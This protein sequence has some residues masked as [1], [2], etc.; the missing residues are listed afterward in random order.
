MAAEEER[1]KTAELEKERE[2]TLQKMVNNKHIKRILTVCSQVSAGL[3]PTK[4][5]N[6]NP[7][8]LLPPGWGNPQCRHWDKV[9][10]A[11]AEQDLAKFRELTKDSTT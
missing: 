11:V 4:R 6:A 1:K 10:Q 9:E 2:E 3:D 8:P 5:T 7:V